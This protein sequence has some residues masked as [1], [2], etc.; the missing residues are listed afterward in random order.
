MLSE[1]KVMILIEFLCVG[2][3]GRVVDKSGSRYEIK[4]VH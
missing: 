1:E 4:E 2:G 3:G